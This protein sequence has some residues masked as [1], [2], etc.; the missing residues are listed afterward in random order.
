[1][2]QPT[3]V[4]GLRRVELITND[5]DGAAL[6][7]Q[8]LLGW[9]VWDSVAGGFE[10]WVGERHCASMRPATHG[11]RPGWY[12]V[13]AGARH[14]GDLVGPDEIT[15]RMVTGRAQ[16]GPWA[17]GPRRGEPCWVDLRTGAPERADAFWAPTLGWAVHD[18]RYLTGGRLLAAR[19]GR[20]VDG[21]WDW[22]CHFATEDVD[23]AAN[24]AVQ[25]GGRVV[26]GLHHPVLGE[27]VVIADP[28]GAVYGLATDTGRW[29]GSPSEG[30]AR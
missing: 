30:S 18:G 22:L 6:F 3:A 17:P 29:G 25:G 2:P 27:V 1:M 4:R 5:L 7:H 28:Q 12:V 20:G 24:R 16:H 15:A 19:S 13:F 26:D 23:L 21:R 11:V 14:D 9:R 8:N 10:C